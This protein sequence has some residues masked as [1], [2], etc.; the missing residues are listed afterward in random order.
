MSNLSPESGDNTLICSSSSIHCF[1]SPSPH[2]CGPPLASPFLSVQTGKLCESGGPG[3]I[4]WQQSRDMRLGRS[5]TEDLLGIDFSYPPLS[6]SNNP[7]LSSASSGESA[8][9]TP[10]PQ[11]AHL[12][13]TS[14]PYHAV[15]CSATAF[16]L[17]LLRCR[18]PQ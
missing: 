9:A 7:F 15:S 11:S 8:A 2:S 16:L 5:Y 12:I 10:E 4:Q 17:V 6:S 13:D 3:R 18:P 1:I 14:C